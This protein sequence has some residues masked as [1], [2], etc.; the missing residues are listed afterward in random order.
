MLPVALTATA[1]AAPAD[2]ACDGGACVGG[3]GAAADHDGEAAGEVCEAGV[4]A[5]GMRISTLRPMNS[6][7]GSLAGERVQFPGERVGRRTEG[8]RDVD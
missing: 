7:W 6:W 4:V 3:G 2:G 5:V 8:H 1:A